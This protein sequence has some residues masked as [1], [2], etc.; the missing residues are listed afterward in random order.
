MPEYKARGWRGT[1]GRKQ[2]QKD[3]LAM[4]DKK[5]L[6]RKVAA[7]Q[8]QIR[9]K[10]QSKAVIRRAEELLRQWLRVKP[11]TARTARGKK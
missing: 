5:K 11:R 3:L 7:K 9:Q 4:S 6:E 8:T 2:L 1:K 10:S